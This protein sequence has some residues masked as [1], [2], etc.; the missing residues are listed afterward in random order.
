MKVKVLTAAEVAERRAA[1]AEAAGL[2]GDRSP[3]AERN[4][5]DFMRRYMRRHGLA[6]V[7]GRRPL[8]YPA[9]WVAAALA[10]GGRGWFERG[11]RR[12]EAALRG[13]AARGRS[14]E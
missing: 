7:D 2:T 12:S 14:V 9:A 6:P 10:E 4:A 11:A 8:V 5:R 1:A 3:R 13:W